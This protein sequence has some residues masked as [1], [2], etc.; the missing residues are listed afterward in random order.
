MRSGT[1]FWLLLLGGTAAAS[2]A[3]YRRR[4]RA[5]SK[6]ALSATFDSETFR[7]AVVDFAEEGAAKKF[8]D[9]LK[10]TGFAVLTNHPVPSTLISSVYREWRDFMVRLHESPDLSAKYYHSPDVQDGYFPMAVSEKAKGATVKDLKHYFQL[11]FPHGKYPDEADVSGDARQLWT[12]LTALGRT[13]VGW[14]D[15]HMPADVRRSIQQKIGEGRTLSECVSEQCTMLRVL[16]YPGYAD[17]EVEAGAVRAAAHEDINLI[18]VL[19]AGS[20]RG[21]QVKSNQTGAWY[22]VPLVEGSIVI[23]IGDMMQEMSDGAYIST[24]HRVIKMDD[25]AVGAAH[26]V[27]GRAASRLFGALGLGDSAAQSGFE[28][29]D[30]MSTPCFI[31]LK[32]KCPMA[33]HGSAEHFLLERLVTLGVKPQK[34]LDDFLRE[35][36]GG[37][38]AGWNPAEE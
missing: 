35:N 24:T 38:M 10:N 23:N 6:P 31:H 9:S 25:A 33:I 29:G 27:L 1:S 30:R 8:T 14:I 12:E 7:V 15:D 11:Y 36:P 5:R 13:L 34:I 17:A 28:S 22:E 20:A 18:T 2:Y 21:L 4:R 26:G 19:P 32:K 3:A 16:H 37:K